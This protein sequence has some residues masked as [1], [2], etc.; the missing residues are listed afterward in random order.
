MPRQIG[1]YHTFA[2]VAALLEEWHAAHP[3]LTALE[4]IAGLLTQGALAGPPGTRDTSPDRKMTIGNAPAVA[5]LARRLDAKTHS[6]CSLSYYRRSIGRTTEGRDLWLLTL[7]D[8]STGAAH[9]KPAFW[10]DGNTHA[11]EVTGTECCL[12]LIETLLGGHAA[13][14][15]ATVALLAGATVYVVPRVLVDGADSHRR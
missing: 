12:H 3:A 9:T 15:K 13:G 5:P 4:Y 7:T 10:C 11:G 14:D 2:E 1:H 8:A 6:S